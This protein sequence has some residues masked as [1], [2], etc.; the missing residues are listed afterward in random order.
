M[1][2]KDIKG[3]LIGK[4]LPLL[5]GVMGG[6]VGEKIGTGIAGVL[7]CDST[8]E[9]IETALQDPEKVLQLKKYEMDHKV[10]L[11]QIELEETRIHLA[12]VQ[13]ARDREI[14][15]TKATGKRDINLYVLAW[16]IVIGFFGLM[17]ILIFKVIPT[18]N[19]SMLNLV[20]GALLGSFTT[21]I[22][23]FFGSSKSSSDKTELMAK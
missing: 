21:V 4:G 1:K 13:S 22:G 18:A 17:G 20:V 6:S 12:D 2:W 11:E 3:M 16:T 9:A 10:E 8:P 23:Y 19:S 7:G 15:T 14:E 5:G